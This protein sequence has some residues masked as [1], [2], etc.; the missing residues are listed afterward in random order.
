MGA[1]IATMMFLIIL[2]GVMVYLFLDPAPHA[3]VFFLMRKPASA[4]IVHGILAL[5]TL[6]ALFPIILVIMNSL[7]GQAGDLQ[8]AAAAAHAVEL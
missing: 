5:Y 8:H 2:C 1:T 3:E 6:L 4:F 7:Q